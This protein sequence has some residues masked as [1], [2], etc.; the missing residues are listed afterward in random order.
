MQAT[1]RQGRLPARLLPDL[2]KNNG[3]LCKRIEKERRVCW[4]KGSRIKQKEA[5][6][7]ELDETRDEKG[8]RG[9]GNQMKEK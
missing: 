4:G 5:G 8:K 9:K 2:E 6:D 7:S 3:K 1:G